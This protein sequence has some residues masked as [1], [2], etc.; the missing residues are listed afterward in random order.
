M[1][2][3]LC[4]RVWMSVGLWK[5]KPALLA[6]SSRDFPW[7]PATVISSAVGEVQLRSGSAQNWPAFFICLQTN[8]TWR[9]PER[10][11]ASA[12]HSPPPVTP[13]TLEGIFKRVRAESHES[14]QHRVRASQYFFYSKCSEPLGSACVTFTPLRRPYVR[15]TPFSSFHFSAAWKHGKMINNVIKYSAIKLC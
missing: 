4:T 14:P 8:L 10:L 9:E 2:A 6:D 5:W 12:E 15:R 7:Q 3:W 1:S 13:R 11:P